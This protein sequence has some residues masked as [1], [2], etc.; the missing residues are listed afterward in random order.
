MHN[1]IQTLKNWISHIFTI[2]LNLKIIF[3]ITVNRQPIILICT[4]FD[5]QLTEGFYFFTWDF[6]LGLK[7][8]FHT[9]KN[10]E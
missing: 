5:C 9:F 6:S 1:Y 7:N 3:P 8:K 10:N 2:K 4:V